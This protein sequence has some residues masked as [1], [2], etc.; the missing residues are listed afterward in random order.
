MS[1]TRRNL[2]LDVA[3]GIG[4]IF[5]VMGH[6]MSPIMSGNGVMEA[7]YQI[8]YV[9]HMPLFFMLSGL[10]APKLIGGDTLSKCELIKQRAVRL[11]IPYFVWAIIYT[12]MKGLLKEQVRFQYA[13]S[14]WT[15]LIG[16][17]PDG[18]LWFLYVLFVLSV[19]T[20]L[21]VNR[22][23][24]KWWCVITVCASIIAP[25]IPSEIG[26]PGISL[27]FS[28]YQIGFFF[29]GILLMPK[30]DA[31]F[32]N[33]KA[34]MLCVFLWLGYSVLLVCNIDVWFIKT[35]AAFCACYSIL[36]FSKM[37]LKTRIS[38]WLAVLG[39]NSMDIYIIHAP[40]LV[41]GRTV[42]R[43]FFSGTPWLY[44]GVLTTAALISALLIS[45]YI[46]RK[47]KILGL[48]LLGIEC[49]PATHLGAGLSH[50]CS[51]LK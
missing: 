45:H 16:N 43:R 20:I 40:M 2:S 50:P 10:V 35:L 4:M 46:V 13:Y 8:L 17:N 47:V 25:I 11:M 9:F 42:L 6:V 41:V 18:Q 51:F 22:E 44:V 12:L 39:R 38:K 24:L 49:P 48:L 37:L 26:L 32:G 3:K 1:S 33:A 34:A 14:P 29:I 19:V 23:N 31:V 27:S 30:M 28:M 21:F 36:S 7:A 5:V 15:I